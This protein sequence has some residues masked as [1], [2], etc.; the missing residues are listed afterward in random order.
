[1]YVSRK[2]LAQVKQDD[3]GGDESRGEEKWQALVAA[4]EASL[5]MVGC[6]GSSSQEPCSVMRLR[7]GCMVAPICTA[8][9]QSWEGWDGAAAR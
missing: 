3:G 4:D 6:Q 9:R 2:G 1:M 7:R 5:I 8:R